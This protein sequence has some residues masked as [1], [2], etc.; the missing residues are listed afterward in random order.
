MLESTLLDLKQYLL[1]H[2]EIESSLPELYVTGLKNFDLDDMQTIKPIILSLFLETVLDDEWT[3]VF[4]NKEKYPLEPH[5]CETYHMLHD[6][7]TFRLL[8]LCHQLFPDHFEDYIVAIV[9]HPN[10]FGITSKAFEMAKEGKFLGEEGLRV[11]D[12][13][14]DHHRQQKLNQA[15]VDFLSQF[16]ERKSHIFQFDISPIPSYEVDNVIQLILE[17]DALMHFNHLFNLEKRALLLGLFMTLDDE[18]L[19]REPKHVE[20]MISFIQTTGLFG[21]HSVNHFLEM[22]VLTH[23]TADIVIK[24]LEVFFNQPREHEYLANILI[25]FS[26]LNILNIDNLL[27]LRETTHIDTV[28]ELFSFL[29]NAGVMTEDNAEDLLIGFLPHLEEIERSNACQLLLFGIAN[30]H[31]FHLEDWQEILNMII[32]QRPENELHDFVMGLLNHQHIGMEHFNFEEFELE[33]EEIPFNPPQST[34]TSSVHASVSES[35]IRLNNTYTI[36]NAEKTVNDMET[37]LQSLDNADLVNAAALRA[38]YAITQYDYR[39]VD[40]VS[41][42]SL[43]DLLLLTWMAIEDDEK[44]IGSKQDVRQLWVESLYDIQR[45]YH[46]NDNPAWADKNICGSGAFNKLIQGIAACHQLTELRYITMQTFAF[47]LKASIQTLM[48]DY[49]KLFANPNTLKAFLLFNQQCHSIEV[50]GV[51]NYWP[52]MKD[53]LQTTLFD[54]FKSLFKDAQDIRFVQVLESGEYASIENLNQFQKEIGAS[55]GYFQFCRSCLFQKLPE[56]DKEQRLLTI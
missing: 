45:D 50:N 42:T 55:K 33:I 7:D 40:K 6:N 36:E 3:L 29:T 31:E 14:I 44:R 37:Y 5:F 56:N 51:G 11:W 53:F 16:L 24:T 10:L 12:E 49:L 4:K 23:D 19:F 1:E 13:F 30:E 26:I 21:L 28:S 47:K 48:I 27:R 52:F 54:E 25:H 17:S 15:I 9:T 35:A 22:A 46:Q 18:G 41:D 20:A 32:N 2:P 34:H 43:Y 39:Y 38:F 8:E